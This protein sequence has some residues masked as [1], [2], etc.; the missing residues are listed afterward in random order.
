[1]TSTYRPD[2]GAVEKQAAEKKTT[3]RVISKKGGNALVEW[4]DPPQRAFLPLSELSLSA[5]GRLADALNPDEG[6][7]YGVPWAEIIGQL[8]ATPEDL[9]RR[10][11]A[12]GIWTVADLLAHPNEL[13]GVILSAFAVDA[14]TIMERAIAWQKHAP[15]QGE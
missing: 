5:D 12:S 8:K 2:Y 4:G 7:V 13:A 14:S 11:R 6:I 9:E 15:E 10:L 1:M 3:V